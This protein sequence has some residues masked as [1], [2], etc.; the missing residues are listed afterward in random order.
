MC[1]MTGV[2]LT[3]RLIK[4]IERSIALRAA[5]P[6]SNN[7]RI[8]TLPREDLR[9]FTA[10]LVIVNFDFHLDLIA[11][12]INIRHEE[13]IRRQ[14]E[15]KVNIAQFLNDVKQNREAISRKIQQ[16]L[17]SDSTIYFPGKK[18]LSTMLLEQLNWL[19]DYDMSLSA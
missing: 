7:L 16:I 15:G 8:T 18:S 19:Q 5:I 9:T 3:E 13:L 17:D 11:Q 1:V 4:E 6:Q 14:S 12:C 10:A 2:E